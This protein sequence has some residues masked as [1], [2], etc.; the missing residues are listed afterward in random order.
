MKLFGLNLSSYLF[1]VAW[2][3]MPGIVYGEY[4][5]F[6]PEANFRLEFNDNRR[7]TLEPHE[8]VWGTIVAGGV[9]VGAMSP[10]VELTLS[11]LLKFSD[12]SGGENITY[13]D[14]FLNGALK[15]NNE[16]ALWT[17]S[18]NYTRDTTIVSELEDSGLVQFDNRRESYDLKPSWTRA[19]SSRINVG[20]NLSYRDVSYENG[21]EIGLFDYTVNSLLGDISFAASEKQQVGFAVFRSAFDVSDIDYV[22]DSYGA[23]LSITSN[24]SERIHTNIT[25][26]FRY[27]DIAIASFSGEIEESD[28]GWLFD[29][30]LTSRLER[31]HVAVNISRSIDPSGLGTE[32]QRDRLRLSLYRPIR[33]RMSGTMAL[34]AMHQED[35]R[36]SSATRARDYGRVSGDLQWRIIPL[37]SLRAGYAFTMQRF[38]NADSE[39]RSNSVYI[40]FEYAG[41]KQQFAS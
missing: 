16:K 18:G 25:G 31:G 13:S 12:Y 40:Q 22:S 26:S 41:R 17:L 8:S 19:I 6:E 20:L 7:L 15:I 37:W 3:G 35:I 10:R 28:R 27:S 33:Q 1:V 30:Q 2:F 21:L 4:W 38:E 11:P 5:Y 36:E 14:Q 23:Q 34:I 9:N 39:A 32:V 24:W 29:A